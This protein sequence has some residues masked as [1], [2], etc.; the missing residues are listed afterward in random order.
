MKESPTNH[1]TKRLPSHTQ[2]KLFLP[3]L[4][5]L[6][7][8]VPMSSQAQVIQKAHCH[9]ATACALPR[10]VQP[11]NLLVVIDLLPPVTSSQVGD[12]QGDLFNE[13]YTTGWGGA[14]DPAPMWYVGGAAGGP[15]TIRL[16]AQAIDVFLAEYPPAALDQVSQQAFLCC[17]PSATLGPLTVNNPDNL[18]ITWV[19]F[20]GNASIPA[21][22][23][24][25]ME[26]D[27][28]RIAIE[29][30]Q[31]AAG[32]YATTIHQVETTTW[33][34]RMVSFRLL[35]PEFS[36]Y[37]APYSPLQVKNCPRGA[38]GFVS[39]C[40]FDAPLEEGT[41]RVVFYVG[42]YIQTGCEPVSDSQNNDWKIFSIT[43]S[44]LS[45]VLGGRG[46]KDTIYFAP[47][48]PLGAIIAEYPASVGLE[49]A[50]YGDYKDPLFHHPDGTQ[51]NL[52][53]TRAVQ[54]KSQCDLL[55]AW[56]VGAQFNLDAE[57][58]VNFN[59]RTYDDSRSIALEDST[60]VLPGAYIASITWSGVAHWDM[61]V[62]AFNMNGCKNGEEMPTFPRPIFPRTHPVVGDPDTHSRPLVN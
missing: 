1:T 3:A 11:G 30:A 24:F 35:G 16:T 61:G 18:L 27:G 40:Q 48:T 36:K 33:G 4:C 21:N 20:G 6:L 49:D 47:N 43:G 53:V 7:L 51:T 56:S 15:V 2:L 23:G 58:G 60:S 5:L 13:I 37:K 26:D 45:Y 29:D 8:C 55:V 10:P 9:L 19:I 39:P 25:T 28:S 41:L 17:T 22:S 50:N 38:N 62:M 32:T 31:V 44:V 12:E 59:L 42:C 57:Q 14:G 52:Q 54:T 34:A 46:G